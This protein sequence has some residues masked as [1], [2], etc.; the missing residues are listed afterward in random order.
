MRPNG[1]PAMGK[2]MGLWFAYCVV[3]GVFAAYLA[4]RTLAPGADYLTVFRI[5]GTVA[6]L[7]YAGG[8]LVD[9][10]WKAQSP[11]T[12]IKGVFDGLVYALLTGGAFGWLWPAA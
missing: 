10:I 11:S 4:G 2:S 5:A 6:F 9:L 3:V 8:E 1:P 7:G 12:T